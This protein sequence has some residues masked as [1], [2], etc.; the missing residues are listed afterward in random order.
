MRTKLLIKEN[1]ALKTQLNVVNSAYYEQVIIYTRV[2]ALFKPDRIVESMLLDVLRDILAAQKEGQ[3]ANNVFGDARELVNNT[4]AEIP[5]MS[6]MSTLKYYWFAI[7]VGLLAQMWTPLTEL[8]T[9][10]RLNGATILAS[11]TFQIMILCLIYRYRQKFATMLLQ[12]NK[13]LFFY[14]VMTTVLMIG[15]FWLIDLMTKN[16]LTIQF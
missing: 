9:H 4:L 2:Q 13:W 10:H 3:I 6:L 1:N 16:A 7:T 14:G 11:I 15:G 12:N 5:N 8:L